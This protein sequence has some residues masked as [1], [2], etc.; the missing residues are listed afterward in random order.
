MS[1]SRSTGTTGSKSES[2]ASKVGT[3]L[4]GTLEAIVDTRAVR[5]GCRRDARRIDPRRIAI[6]ADRAVAFVE[7]VLHVGKQA[8]VRRDRQRAA[9][10]DHVIAG[11]RWIEIGLITA[12]VRTG[13]EQQ[14]S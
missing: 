10:T 8:Q 2:Y 5:L 9:Q 3:R 14:R 7:Q 12:V 4:C 1:S 13:G 11:Q 6:Q